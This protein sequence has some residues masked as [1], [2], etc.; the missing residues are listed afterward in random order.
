M[1]VVRSRRTANKRGEEGAREVEAENAVTETGQWPLLL[2]LLVVVV[3]L[4]QD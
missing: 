1:R 3:V 2:L 4:R